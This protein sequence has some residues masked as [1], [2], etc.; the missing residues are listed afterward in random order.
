MRLQINGQP[1]DAPGVETVDQLLRSLGLERAPCAVEVNGRLVPKPTH[2]A[3]ALHEG[4]HVEIV[5]LVGG[6]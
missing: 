3:Q 1:K 5:T 6:G 2:A 4:D